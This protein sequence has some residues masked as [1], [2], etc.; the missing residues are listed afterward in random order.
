MATPIH[1]SYVAAVAA[2]DAYSDLCLA[3]QAGSGSPSETDA[4]YGEGVISA[5][6]AQFALTGELGARAA[7]R[8]LAD[9]TIDSF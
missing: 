1:D 7:N 8:I 6:F 3:A 4:L 5:D 9:E 2:V